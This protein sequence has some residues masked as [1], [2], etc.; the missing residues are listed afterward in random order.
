R[1]R[2][3]GERR[4]FPGRLRRDARLPPADERVAGEAGEWIVLLCPPIGER[5]CWPGRVLAN[6]VTSPYIGRVGR[7]A[8]RSCRRR[9]PRQ[10]ESAHCYAVERACLSC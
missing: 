4:D 7:S 8:H 6:H 1:V 9:G 2:V 3:C 5:A 10:R